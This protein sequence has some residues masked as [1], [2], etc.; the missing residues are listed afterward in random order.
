MTIRY[1]LKELIEIKE[2]REGK[3][4]SQASIAREIGVQRSAINKIVNDSEYVTT[5]NT[6]DLLCKYFDSLAIASAF[7]VVHF[8]HASLKS[9]LLSKRWS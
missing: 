2:K 8:V 5:T 6:L 3:K 4:I 7:S 1:K 9:C